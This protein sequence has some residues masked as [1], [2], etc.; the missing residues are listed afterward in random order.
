MATNLI[1]EI[2]FIQHAGVLKRVRIWLFRFTGVKLQYYCYIL[3][4]FDKDRSSNPEDY[5]GRNCTILDEMAKNWHIT[6][7]L[8]YRHQHFSIGRHMY[9]DYKLT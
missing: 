6:P 3:C 2:T 4:N 9:G 8:K 1:G 5:E 7:N